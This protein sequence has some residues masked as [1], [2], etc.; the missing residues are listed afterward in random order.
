MVVA[1][2]V[3]AYAV[4]GL[5]WIGY[6][7]LHS[8]FAAMW[9]KRAVAKRWPT[10][11]PG[12]R[13]LFNLLSVVLLLP[14]LWMLHSL[15]SEPLIQWVGV[16]QWLANGL[17]LMALGGFFWTLRFYSGSEFL[18]LDQWRFKSRPDEPQQHFTL[19][20]LHRFVRHPWYSLALVLIWTRDLDP[21]MCLSAILI[22]LYFIVGSML[23]ERKL[24]LLFGERYRRYQ[25][26]VPGLIPLPWKWLRREEAETLVRGPD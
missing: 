2:N 26:Q 21:A 7:L 19:S 4:L 23:E 18:G 5:L 13:L 10:L 1:G 11:M 12:Y 25:H 20:P 9:F 8:L 6:F 16:W 24:V 22:S 15:A 17:A 3:T 14:P